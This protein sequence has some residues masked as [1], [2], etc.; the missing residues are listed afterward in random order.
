MLAT[1]IRLIQDGVIKF[2][3]GS[4]FGQVPKTEWE[5]LISADRKNRITMGLNCMLLQTAGKNILVDTGIGNKEMNGLKQ[6]Y[7]L[8]PSRLMKNLRH[9]NL[10]PK[11]I[12]SV[13][14][15]NLHFDHCG[16]ST[17]LDRTGELVP[18]F[19]KASYYIQKA[20]WQEANDPSERCQHSY[21]DEDFAPIE[22]SGQ[23]ELVDGDYELLPGLWVKI[24]GGPS[25]GHQVVVMNHGG[26]KVAFMGD[27]IPTPYHLN[28][29]CTSA[30]DQFPE[31]SMSMKREL[32]EQAVDEGWLI[33]FSHGRD[34][35][36]GYIEA[37]N[38]KRHLKPIN[39]G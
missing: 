11:D 36:A 1:S 26:E 39:L 29:S 6:Q 35:Q 22:D 4:M 37:R 9:L 17:R 15:T 3:G 21:K 23:L 20:C 10:T 14:L 38:G 32:I 28:L 30:F 13:I 27:L 33:I 25:K 5:D 24:T 18:T 16:G 8:V 19:P 12:D 34:C 31:E 2:D 7:G